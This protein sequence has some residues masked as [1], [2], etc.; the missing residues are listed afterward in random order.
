MHKNSIAL[1]QNTEA[2]SNGADFHKSS[3]KYKKDRI[4][5][6]RWEIIKAE[7]LKIALEILL[8]N[9]REIQLIPIVDTDAFKEVVQKNFKPLE[10]WILNDL[11]EKR[12]EK[13]DKQIKEIKSGADPDLYWDYHEYDR[14]YETVSCNHVGKPVYKY[15]D[16]VPNA[17]LAEMEGE[18]E[19]L[20]NL[21]SELNDLIYIE[22]SKKELE[23]I[24][25]VLA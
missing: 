2:L 21:Y 1:N 7:N 20:F 11:I 17:Q 19:A 18:R 12:H 23:F 10:L 25:Q 16:Y 13:L 22:P 14:D 9:N 8:N 6:Y 4:T 15:G 5:H 3:E 24:E